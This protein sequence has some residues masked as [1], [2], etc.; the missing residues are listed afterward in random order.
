MEFEVLN[1]QDGVARVVNN[2]GLYAKLLSKFVDSFSDVA[3]KIILAL[4]VDDLEEAQRQAHT[5]K[6]TAANLGAEKLANIGAKLEMAIKENKEVDAIIDEFRVVF[7]E[8]CEAIHAF[9]A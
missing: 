5:I 2:R 7:L 1:W 6:G 9:E 4:G 3:D 8:T